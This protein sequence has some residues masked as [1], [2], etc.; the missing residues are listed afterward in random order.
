MN[1]K[2]LHFDQGYCSC[3]GKLFVI[4]H[5][6]YGSSLKCSNPDCSLKLKLYDVK[7]SP[8]PERRPAKYWPSEMGTHDYEDSGY[9]SRRD[10]REEK[11]PDD[12]CR[13]PDCGRP[14]SCK[15]CHSSDGP[16][17]FGTMGW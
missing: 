16:S 2:D 4:T 1:E 10:R 12:G 14:F 6:E 17:G 11:E 5:P 9:D 7:E 15:G 13:N 8:R 3:K